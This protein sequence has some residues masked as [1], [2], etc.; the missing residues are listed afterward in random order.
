M[1]ALQ[2]I[3]LL[4]I[5]RFIMMSLLLKAILEISL[6]AGFLLILACIKER[7]FRIFGL[8]ACTAPLRNKHLIIFVALT[9]EI[10]NI[11]SDMFYD[12]I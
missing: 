12:R 6:F 1:F 7:W 3:S 4:C 5:H 11:I 8:L 9:E 10:K 2:V